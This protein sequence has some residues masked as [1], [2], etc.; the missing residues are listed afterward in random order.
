MKVFSRLR[1]YLPVLAFAFVAILI[2]GWKLG[3]KPPDRELSDV[4]TFSK[5]EANE[6]LAFAMDEWKQV[7][8]NRITMRL[9]Q[10]ASTT[11]TWS[12]RFW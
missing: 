3:A 8:E 6:R 10:H 1:G 7:I 9:T 2:V 11:F 5:L 12:K 4:D